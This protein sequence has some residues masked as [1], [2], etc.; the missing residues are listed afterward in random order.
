MECALRRYAEREGYRNEA[1]DSR[2]SG[3]LGAQSGNFIKTFI[4][5]GFNEDLFGRIVWDGAF[6]RIAARQTP[7]NFRFALPGG[8]V[9]LYEPGSEGVL[10]WS[11]YLDTT[12]GRPQPASLLDRCT[13]AVLRS[14]WDGNHQP[15]P[16]TSTTTATVT[17]T[18]T[19]TAT[20]TATATATATPTSTDTPTETPKT[21]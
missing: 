3:A 14:P 21:P 15:A 4:H 10:T 18:P 8:A 11:R 19:A 16:S 12:R 13:G 17:A 20:G 7:M 9:D 1:I 5:L 6:P 2:I